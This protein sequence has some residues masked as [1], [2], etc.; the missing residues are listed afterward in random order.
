MIGKTGKNNH[1]WGEKIDFPLAH[2]S[3]R[4]CL[5]GCGV[6]KVSRH[7]HEAGADRHW[8]EFFRDGEKIEGTGTP[9]C[10]KGVSAS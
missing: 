10:S 2:K 5:N 6:T 1:R 4:T 3:E 9:A 7:E 8:I